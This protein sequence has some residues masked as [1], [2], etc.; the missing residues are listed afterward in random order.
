MVKQKDTQISNMM[1]NDFFNEILGEQVRDQY[2]NDPIL[3]TTKTKPLVDAITNRHPIT[4][5]YSGPRKPKSK[6]VKAGYRVKAEAVALGLNKKGVLVVRAYVDEPSVSKR[7]T[8]TKVGIVKSNYGWRTFHAVRMTNIQVL[9]NE[10]FNTVREKYNNGEDDKSMSVTY[11]TTNFSSEPPK[12]K[13]TKPK[14]TKLKPAPAVKPQP[15]PTPTTSTVKT[16]PT[17]TVDL[18]KAATQKIT[19]KT[20]AFDQEIS[21]AQNDLS[22][23]E[24]ELK[25]NGTKIANSVGTPEYQNYL[26]IGKDLTA[27]KK[28]LVKKVDDLVNQLAQA[29]VNQKNVDVQKHL[30]AN[31]VRNSGLKEIPKKDKPTSSPEEEDE[32][33][34]VNESFINRIK[35]LINKMEYL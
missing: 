32:E 6:S 9:K 2:K 28:E 35:K 10:T 16:K 24:K 18:N 19:K 8:P 3:K 4:F 29:G 1:L 27:K 26:N 11:V 25:D 22:N 13:V 14:A 15:E 34:F 23:I 17:K 21:A 20:R 12:P 31:S 33:N 7:G 5:Y 30:S